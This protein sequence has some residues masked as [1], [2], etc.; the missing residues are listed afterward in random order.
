MEQ[1][2][3]AADIVILTSDNEGTPLSLIQ[4]GMAELP[5]VTT[6]VGSVPEVVLDGITGIVTSLNVQ[7]IADALE[8]LATSAELRVQM[9]NSARKFTLANF[10]IKRLVNDHEV[11]Y[12][13]LIANR[14]KS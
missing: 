6:L 4:A 2:L 5:V 9:G 14:A 1:V 11:L 3:S 12:K 13:K 8:K 10:G 7:Q